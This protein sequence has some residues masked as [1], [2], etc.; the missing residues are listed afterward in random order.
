M[1]KSN[2]VVVSEVNSMDVQEK[3][4]EVSERITR[5]EEQNKTL[6]TTVQRLEGKLDE[7]GNGKMTRLLTE[8]NNQMINKLMELIS[9]D[10]Q[11]EHDIESQKIDESKE[12]KLK[13]WHVAGL[14]LTAGLP[15]FYEIVKMLIK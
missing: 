3:L 12:I 6:F 15:G 8:T 9:S 2:D 14:F 4:H 1:N 11:H 13:K 7:L 10:Q 5:I